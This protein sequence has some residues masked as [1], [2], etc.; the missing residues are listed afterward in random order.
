MRV[1]V[2]KYMYVCI[3]KC[4]KTFVFE[5]S[6]RLNT[7]RTLSPTRSIEKQTERFELMKHA[8]IC[9]SANSP[10][11][12]FYAVANQIDFRKTNLQ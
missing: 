5:I 2:C 10:P 6:A 8:P 3:N 1:C 7:T 4:K 11:R 9:Y 12:L